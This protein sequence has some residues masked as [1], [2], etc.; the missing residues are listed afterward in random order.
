MAVRGSPLSGPWPHTS[1][2]A[3]NGGGM[4]NER[5]ARARDCED[6]YFAINQFTAWINNADAKA[7]FLSAALA[8]LAGGI[9]RES[10]ER[11]KSLGHLDAQQWL[12]IAAVASS[13]IVSI[14]SAA[15]LVR[16]IYPRIQSQPFSRYSWPSVANVSHASLL[17]TGIRSNRDEA[18]MTALSLA[19][20]AKKKFRCLRVSFACW[21]AAIVLL[22]ISILM[23]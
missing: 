5:L 1:E 2:L 7:G 18:W 4:R 22:L 17:K 3:A 20:I 14:V 15:Y 23:T 8:I 9:A 13:A 11:F 16:A 12:V 21:M 19:L 10:N 6:A